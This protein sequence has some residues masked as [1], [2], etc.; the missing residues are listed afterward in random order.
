MKIIQQKQD[1]TIGQD[2]KITRAEFVKMAARI[3]AYSQCN[4]NKNTNTIESA[5]GIRDAQDSPIKRNRF[6]KGEKFSFVPIVSD[7]KWEYKWTATRLS[8]GSI[9]R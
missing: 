7:G 1:N 5:I 2:E 8:D 4:T 3:L 9:V 6:V